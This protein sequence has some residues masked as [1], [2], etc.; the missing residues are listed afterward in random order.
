M[1]IHLSQLIDNANQKATD[2]QLAYGK[3]TMALLTRDD[4]TME[5]KQSILAMMEPIKT[6]CEASQAAFS[7]NVG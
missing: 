4:F 1:S 5:Q 2:V 7:V 6:A 3:V